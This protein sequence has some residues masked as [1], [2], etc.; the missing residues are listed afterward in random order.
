MAAIFAD[1]KE[2]MIHF[3]GNFCSWK[4]LTLRGR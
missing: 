3:M 2:N 4:E 1:E